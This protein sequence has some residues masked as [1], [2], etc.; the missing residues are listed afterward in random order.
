MIK[1]IILCLIIFIVAFSIDARPRHGGGRDGGRT[2]HRHHGRHGHKMSDL[3]KAAVIVDMTVGT[4]ATLNAISNSNNNYSS[5]Y[6]APRPEYT[7]GNVYIPPPADIVPSSPQV[8]PVQPKVVKET[9][10][11]IRGKRTVVTEEEYEKVIITRT[12]E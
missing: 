11:K 3:E 2:H 9:I 10:V 6:I 7:N 4:I 5:S 1:K 8:Q 12:Y